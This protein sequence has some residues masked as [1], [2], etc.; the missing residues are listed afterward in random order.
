MIRMFFLAS[1]FN[2]DISAWDVS[3]V[4]TMQFMFGGASSFDQDIASWDVSSVTGM[5][6]MFNDASAFHQN[7]CV[8]GYKLQSTSNAFYLFSN[9][10]C[11]SRTATP[12]F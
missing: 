1:S 3:S 11:P 2:H 10:S 8:W 4:T 5:H 12:S 7:M 9:T 6:L